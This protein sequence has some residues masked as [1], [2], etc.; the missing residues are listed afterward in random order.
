MAD[1]NIDVF[2]M[3]ATED[4]LDGD[5]YPMWAYMMHHV[6]VSKGV[7]NIVQGIDVHPGSVDV[8]KV[9]DVAGPSTRIAIASALLLPHS[10]NKSAKQ[11]WDIL[12]SLYAG[13][14]EA[15]VHNACMS[16]ATDSHVW[17]FDS[18]ATKHITSHHDLFTSLE[19]VPHGNSVTCANNAS[20]PVQGVGKIVL[21]A[22]NGSSFT[23][24]DALYVPGIKKNLLSVCALARFG[25]V[26]KFV[27]DKCTIHDLGFGDEIVASGILCRGLYKLTLYDKCGQNFANVVVDT[28]A[29]SDA[30]L[31]HARFGHLNFASLLRLQK[32]DMVASLPSLEAPVKHVCEGC[33]LGKM[34]HSKFPKDGLE[35]LRHLQM[36]ADLEAERAAKDQLERERKE[37][38]Q[39]ME[40]DLAYESE[41][42]VKLEIGKKKEKGQQ[43][44]DQ[45]EERKGKAEEKEK[46]EDKE[47]AEKK[48]TV[49]KRGLYKR[50]V[51]DHLDN[52]SPSPQV[53]RDNL[54]CTNDGALV[55]ELKDLHAWGDKPSKTPV[56]IDFP[57][58]PV[59]FYPWLKQLGSQ[60]GVVLGQ[61]A[62][63]GFNP[64]W[65][66]QLLVEVDT[67]QE[68]RQ[69]IP[70]KDSSGNLIKNCPELAPKEPENNTVDPKD[71]P[72]Q[73]VQRRK[74]YRRNRNNINKAPQAVLEKV[75]DP[76]YYGTLQPETTSQVET[77]SPKT[78][79]PEPENNLSNLHGK[80]N[81]YQSSTSKTDEE[82]ILSTQ[83]ICKDNPLRSFEEELEMAD[84][85]EKAQLASSSIPS[86]DQHMSKAVEVLPILVKGKTNRKKEK[87]V[88]PN[89]V[90]MIFSKPLKN[91]KK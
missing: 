35:N 25:L 61:K 67:K 66:P 50:P 90:S 46:A 80:D 60:I 12:A 31:W 18:G 63:G 41:E 62:R 1:N 53:Q 6:L 21:T 47:K 74:A 82:T 22:A 64:K 56:W 59:E 3:F 73:Q 10:F 40:D 54:N 15:A 78:M 52:A 45:E 36:E 83:Q 39:Q 43:R 44:G 26:V 65:D 33:I 17:Y 89:R 38:E 34:Q 58:L 75:F 72:F 24:V 86:N 71:K 13:R 4:R 42:K 9:V 85:T 30:K 48:K 14:N 28:K 51:R 2:K 76:F 69:E 49:A 77:L 27:D 7:W 37:K 84:A 68:L 20:Y 79:N 23:L 88:D 29:I 87:D 57:D 16:I 32:Y 70:I 8:A 5:N 19:S 11:A 55:I 91:S 81:S